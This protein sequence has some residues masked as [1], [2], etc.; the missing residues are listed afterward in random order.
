MVEC[1]VQKINEKFF[2]QKIKT[3]S[4]L[5]SH[6]K[7]KKKKNYSGKGSKQLRILLDFPVLIFVAVMTSVQVLG[8]WAKVKKRWA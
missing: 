5:L 4:S 2:V 6:K 8:Y 7:K 3:G 1:V